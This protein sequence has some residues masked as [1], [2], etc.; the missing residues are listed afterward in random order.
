VY[1][2]VLMVDAKYSN[3]CCLFESF[4]IEFGGYGLV[5]C[6]LWNLVGK[7]MLTCVSSNLVLYGISFVVHSSSGMVKIVIVF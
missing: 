1:F 2:S 5:L 7:W 3:R 6:I 4:F